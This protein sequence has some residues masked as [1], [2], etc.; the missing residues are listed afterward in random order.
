MAL[1]FKLLPRYLITFGPIAG[2]VLFIKV[3]VICQKR[4]RL[5]G[6]RYPIELRTGTT[7][8]LVFREVFLF[9][10]YDF[11]WTDPKI[12]IDG[13]GNIG[14]TSIF[15][16]EK[17]PQAKI[18][19]IEPSD[20]NFQLLQ[21][22]T[23]PYELIVP[24]H[25]ALWNKDTSLIIKDKEESHWAF[26][27][28]ECSPD[29]PDSFKAISIA[30]L[31]KEQNISRVDILKLDIEGAERELFTANYEYWI[32]RTKCILVELHDWLKKDCSKNVFVTISKY[33]FKTTIFNGMLVFINSD[34]D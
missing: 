23:T 16:A 1:K 19:S 21:K 22:N 27:V 24:I 6:V 17:F 13:G 2:M 33:N 20:S 31:L 8:K 14:L 26:A 11:S 15:F 25:S 10:S 4:L 32:S 12:I 3:E 30:S 29:H 9:K 28:E 7:D 18:F 34:I 5:K